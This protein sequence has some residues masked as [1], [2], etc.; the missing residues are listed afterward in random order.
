ME[1]RRRDKKFN[2]PVEVTLFVIG[3][4]WKSV[5]LWHLKSGPKRF[6]VL[7]KLIPAVTVRMLTHQLR[8]LEL[9]G[10]VAREIFPEVPPRVEYSLTTKG[11]SLRPI[12]DAL[13]DWGK[14]HK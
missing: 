1:P 9:D 6:T 7:R 4:K 11:K 3:G 2:C 8:E 5:I 12:L 13:C 10:V 14:K